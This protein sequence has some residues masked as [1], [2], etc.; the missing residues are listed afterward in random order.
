[1]T[2]LFIF[3]HTSFVINFNIRITLILEDKLVKAHIK[4]KKSNMSQNF[5]WVVAKILFHQ[6]ELHHQN[7]HFGSGNQC[8]KR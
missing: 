6:I 8:F 4:L 3:S 5:Q 7:F 2:S 1:M